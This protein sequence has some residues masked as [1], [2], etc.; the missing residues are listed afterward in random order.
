MWIIIDAAR[1]GLRGLASL[2]LEYVK[3]YV[4]ERDC[5]CDRDWER[6][7]DRDRERERDLDRDRDGERDLDRD[8]DG[9]RDRDIVAGGHISTS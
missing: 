3:W 4:D 5:D 1:N 9:D 8:L 2:A 7:C 6:D